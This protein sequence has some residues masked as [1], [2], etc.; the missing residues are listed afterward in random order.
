MKN[1]KKIIW[2]IF[3]I[4]VMAIIFR[5]SAEKAGESAHTSKRFMRVLIDIF[6]FTKYLTEIAKQELMESMDFIIRKCAHFTL[7]AML[8]FSVYGAVEST[9]SVTVKLNI[10]Y[11]FV[12]CV[13]YAVSDEIHQFFVP[14]RA[15]RVYDI[16]I[17]S[18]GSIF[19]ISAFLLLAFL[20]KKFYGNK[21]KC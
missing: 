16:I 13:L 14:G 11:S 4:L 19:G 18:I 6:P 15:C 17:D 8:G 20:I 21:I 3:V 1:I 7:Y 2:W 10:M 12:I 5:F 9:L